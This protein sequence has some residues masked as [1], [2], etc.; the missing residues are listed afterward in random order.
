MKKTHA[1]AEIDIVNDVAAQQVSM[2]ELSVV[3]LK[4]GRDYKNVVSV[5]RKWMQSEKLE[6]TIFWNH[7]DM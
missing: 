4:S 5:V 7:G 3:P 1:L 6:D 2:R